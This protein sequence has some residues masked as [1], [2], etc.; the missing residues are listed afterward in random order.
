MRAHTRGEH[1]VPALDRPGPEAF[2]FPELAAVV[3]MFV[4]APDVVHEHVQFSVLALDLLQ[5]GADLLVAEVIATDGD[6]AAAEFGDFVS[7]GADR[8]AE[9]HSGG[10]LFRG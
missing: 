3:E 10:S 8:S 6:G 4:A 7:G 2:L 1:L 9:P 5:H